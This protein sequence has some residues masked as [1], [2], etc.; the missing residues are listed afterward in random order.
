MKKVLKLSL[1]GLPWLILAVMTFY[2]IAYDGWR[3]LTFGRLHRVAY[4]MFDDPGGIDE[5][6]IYLL[7]GE[8]G[9]ESGDV[10]PVRPYGRNAETYG[11]ISLTGEALE[12]FKTLWRFMALELAYDYQALCHHPP[13]GFQ[14]I[15]ENQVK[16]E[17]SICWA[18]SNFYVS[19]LGTSAWYGFNSSG[20]NSEALLNFC[21]SLMPYPK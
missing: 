21:D 11:V 7:Q 20:P 1:L 2:L 16:V 4:E 3:D 18:C 15:E 5:V 9:T 6:R 17:T 8:E 19:I 12:E 14:L 10:F 13:Y